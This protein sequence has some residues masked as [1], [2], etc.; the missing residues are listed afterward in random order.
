MDGPVRL[1]PYAIG[2]L[3]RIAHQAT[4]ATRLIETG[5]PMAGLP[6]VLV[7][8]AVLIAVFAAV[9]AALVP[10]V[11]GIFGIGEVLRIRRER[12]ATAR[13]QREAQETLDDVRP[14]EVFEQRLAGEALDE[15][16]AGRLRGLHRQ[17]LDELWEGEA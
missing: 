10:I 5:V 1:H 14:E 3:G 15:A 4:N 6:G 2:W 17:V 9:V 13:L 8:F 11:M 7:A 12:S 16:L